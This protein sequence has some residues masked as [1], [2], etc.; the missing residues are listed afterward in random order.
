MGLASLLL[1]LDM[2][3]ARPTVLLFAV[4]LL[5][6]SVLDRICGMSC[7]A[8]VARASSPAP[9]EP[10]SCHD[11][12][13]AA[14]PTGGQEPAGREPCGDHDSMRLVAARETVSPAFAV[15][16]LPQMAVATAPI[17]VGSAVG[18]PRGTTFASLH[19]SSPPGRLASILRI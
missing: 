3:F 16:A 19:G 9:Q 1:P 17:V 18:M 4:A 2:R 8:E 7:V 5:S 15:R 6:A 11:P 13:P 10:I 14:D 12:E